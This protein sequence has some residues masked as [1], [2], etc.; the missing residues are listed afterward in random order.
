MNWTRQELYGGVIFFV[1]AAVLLL[2]PHV[3]VPGDHPF[4]PRGAAIVRDMGMTTFDMSP[5]ELDADLQTSPGQ[6]V[7]VDIRSQTEFEHF[8]LPGATHIAFEDLIGHRG[9]SCQPDRRIIVYDMAGL[10]GRAAQAAVL[11]RMAD[12]HAS[13][14]RGG[15]VAWLVDHG[16]NIDEALLETHRTTLQAEY[17]R[18]GMDRKTTEGNRVAAPPPTQPETA[19]VTPLPQ[20]T[21]IQREGC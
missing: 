5:G 2:K 3:A 10:D 13:W 4:T 18:L 1:L 8:H 17:S 9:P 14:L 7:L 15:L 11:L 20:R 21:H 6:L 12:C 16:Y 19:P